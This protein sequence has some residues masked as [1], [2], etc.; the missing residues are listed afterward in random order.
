MPFRGAPGIPETRQTPS[1]QRSYDS[2]RSPPRGPPDGGARPRIPRSTCL[3]FSAG[4]FNLPMHDA[5]ARLYR[6][7]SWLWRDGREAEGDGLLNRYTGSNPYPGFESPSLRF[8]FDNP[9]TSRGLFHF[10]AACP[11]FAKKTSQAAS[12]LRRRPSGPFEAVTAS[13]RIWDGGLGVVAGGL[14]PPLG[15]CAPQ[16]EKRSRNGATNSRSKRADRFRSI[17]AGGWDTATFA[18]Y[19]PILPK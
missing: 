6:A 8:D 14:S 4:P 19:S 1:C 15:L 13:R 18:G 3:R 17:A 5:T 12:T 2:Y 11:I 7:A 16:A 10:R 9:R